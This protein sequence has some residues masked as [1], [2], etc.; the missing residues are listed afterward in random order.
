MTPTIAEKLAAFI[1]QLDYE[2]LSTELIL[3]AK[4]LLLDQLGCQLVGSTVPWN[5][6]VYRFVSENKKGGSARIVNYGDRVPADDAAL[7]NATFGQGCELDDYYDQG[8]GHPGSGSIPAVLAL[9]GNQKVSGK[10]LVAAMAAGYDVGWCVGRGLLPGMM[11]RGYHPQ[12]VIGV[13]VASATAGKILRLNQGQMTHALAIAGSHAAGTMEYDQSGGEVKRLHSGM[14]CSGGLRSAMLAQLGLTGPPTIFEGAR[15]V[16]K[17]FGGETDPD[18]VT[19]NLGKES[20]VLRAAIKRFPVNASQH[21]PI[22]LLDKLVTEHKIAAGAIETIEVAVNEGV[23]L[24]GGAIEKPKEAIEA[25]FSLRFSLGVRLL[26]GSNDLAFYLD[27]KVWQDPEVLKIGKK[28]KLSAD[29]TATGP[30]RFA[31][32]MKITRT[33]GNAAEGY[34]SAPKGTA[35]NPLTKEE[36]RD[37]FRRLGAGILSEKRLNGILDKVDRLELEND[38]TAIVQLLTPGSANQAE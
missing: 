28:T 4:D 29:P 18:L 26:K 21:S 34:L 6:A 31:C 23:L 5:Q 9:A 17:V 22:E 3:K 37:K 35:A 38:V 24:H 11:R 10:D 20:A 14:A 12:G 2:D 30:R 15:G 32:R 7:V 1:C 33:N 27:P 13:F 19:E 25:Q 16:L 8:G 36:V